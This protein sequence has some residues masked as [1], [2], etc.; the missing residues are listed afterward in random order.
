MNGHLVC[1]NVIDFADGLRIVEARGKYMQA[2]PVGQV[3]WQRLV[4]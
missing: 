4:G 3:L 2:V 1:A